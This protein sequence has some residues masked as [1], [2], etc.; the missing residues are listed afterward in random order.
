MALPVANQNGEMENDRTHVYDDDDDDK[1]KLLERLP[2]NIAPLKEI[3]LLAQGCILLLYLK[4]HL[5]D[6]FGFT[7]SKIQNY[8]PT[9]AAKVY[10]KPL[11]RKTLVKFNP[12]SV[13]NVMKKSKAESDLEDEEDE[14]RRDREK[15]VNDYLEFKDLMLSVDPPDEDDSD[16]EHG[17]QQQQRT[18]TPRPSGETPRQTIELAPDGAAPLS[19]PLPD[20]VPGSGGAPGRTEPMVN[21][22]DKGV[23]EID[24]EG[25]AE[26]SNFDKESP[27]SVSE[28]TKPRVPPVIINTAKLRLSE[29]DKDR[30][31][32]SLVRTIR[33]PGASQLQASAHSH[34]HTP[35]SQSHSHSHRDSSSTP[36][37]SHHRSAAP[38]SSHKKKKSK[39]KRRKYTSDSDDDDSDFDPD[40]C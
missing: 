29:K 11:T 31:R 14:D 32:G 15:V 4:Q 7:D 22:D 39:K 2:R 19:K 10:D 37:R 26:P 3:I 18:G 13:L 38:P 8:S 20:G 36:S 21:G 6:T 17:Q 24:E 28:I 40:N 34:S 16:E 33:L 12:E 27:S 23:I 9:E 25:D 35:S 5:K 1:N 30:K